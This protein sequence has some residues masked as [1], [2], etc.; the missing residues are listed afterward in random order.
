MFQVTA[1]DYLEEKLKV[2]QFT[3]AI[4]ELSMHCQMNT[5]LQY[6]F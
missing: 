5:T 1:P 6:S 2:A 4:P 3:K